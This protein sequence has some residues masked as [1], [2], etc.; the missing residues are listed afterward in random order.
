M[1]NDIYN[2]SISTYQHIPHGNIDIRIWTAT[3]G[4]CLFGY[5]FGILLCRF[6]FWLGTGDIS[7]LELFSDADTK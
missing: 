5:L 1:I 2:S 6:A 7:H 3:M 4:A